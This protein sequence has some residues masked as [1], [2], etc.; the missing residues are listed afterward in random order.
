MTDAEK[1]EAAKKAMRSIADMLRELLPPQLGFTLLVFD[2][3]DAGSIQY[4][5]T[6]HREDMK[7]IMRQLLEKWDNNQMSGGNLD[8]S[9]NRN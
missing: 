3:S 2:Y 1:A 5:S 6:G 7:R 4:I 8:I 9:P